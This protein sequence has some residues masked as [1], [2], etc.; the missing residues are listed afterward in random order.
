MVEFPG[1]EGE[2]LGFGEESSVSVSV[3]A[4]AVAVVSGSGG[5]TFTIT[6]ATGT[7]PPPPPPSFSDKRR[8]PF[9]PLYIQVLEFVGEERWISGEDLVEL[10]F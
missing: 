8:D 1:D 7:V 4:V 2:E 9:V 3:S 6:I 10:R 5:G